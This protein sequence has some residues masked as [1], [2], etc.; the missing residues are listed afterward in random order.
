MTKTNDA[1]FVK[2][3]ETL[4]NEYLERRSERDLQASLRLQNLATWTMFALTDGGK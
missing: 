3:L 1:A 2:E 4:H